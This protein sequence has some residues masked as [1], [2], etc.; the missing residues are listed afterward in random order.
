MAAAVKS[1]KFRGKFLNTVKTMIG[2]NTMQRALEKKNRFTRERI[3]AES[4]HQR[5]LE[6]CIEMACTIG[7]LEA[8]EFLVDECGV[9]IDDIKNSCVWS[10]ASERHSNVVKYFIEKH[11]VN[12]NLETNQGMGIIHYA[13]IAGDDKFAEYLVKKGADLR[14][15]DNKKVNCLMAGAWAGSKKICEMAIKA[16]VDVNAKNSNGEHVLH[17]TIRQGYNVN[18]SRLNV[19][20]YLVKSGADVNSVNGSNIP[21]VIYAALTLNGC[22]KTLGYFLK[23]PKVH[24][25]D[26]IEAIKFAGAFLFSQGNEKRG[27]RF[28]TRAVELEEKMKFGKDENNNSAPSCY[29]FSSYEP[30]CVADVERL[31]ECPVSPIR[32]MVAL[33]TK[34]HIKYGYDCLTQLEDLT[35]V[36]LTLGFYD[37]YLVVFSFIF[38]HSFQNNE[39]VNAIPQYDAAF[40]SICAILAWEAKKGEEIYPNVLEFFAKMASGFEQKHSQCKTVVDNKEEIVNKKKLLRDMLLNAFDI[41]CPSDD[42][43]N[44]SDCWSECDDYKDGKHK[45]MYM[46]LMMKLSSMILKIFPSHKEE[47]RPYL[48]KLLKTNFR[49]EKNATFLQVA[50]ECID[51]S[52]YH[53]D[54][55]IQVEL[56]KM[57]IEEGVNVNATDNYNCTAI[58]SLARVVYSGNKHLIQ[59]ILD[60]MLQHGAHLDIFNNSGWSGLDEMIETNVTVY[61]VANRSLQCLAAKVVMEEGLDYHSSTPKALWEF[62]ELHD[63][64]VHVDEDEIPYAYYSEE[65]HEE[66]ECEIY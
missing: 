17:G 9:V 58:H 19:I 54:E 55:E 45:N 44:N 38:L 11:S 7:N 28:W 56:V 66:H 53:G 32:F 64:Q 15:T 39:N 40:R 52:D 1:G 20:D 65:Q 12:V 47:F 21:V 50:I 46:K 27:F 18:Q 42:E 2:W 59:E 22:T 62:I 36:I 23:H 63:P 57:L 8:V 49:D 24:M 10:A 25:H 16:G 34:L 14:S 37:F 5:E 31:R 41:V 3:I 6:I 60:L 35:D 48:H 26:K 30:A 33:L 51:S 43:D 13:C 4:F 29:D 61:P